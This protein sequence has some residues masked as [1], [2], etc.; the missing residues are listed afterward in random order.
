MPNSLFTLPDD[1]SNLTAKQL[2]ELV[3]RQQAIVEAKDRAYQEKDRAYQEKERAYQEIERAYQE[4]ARAYQQKD[5]AYRHVSA[6]YEQ[7]KME[8]AILRRINFI[9]RSEQLPDL[10]SK[11]FKEDAETDLADLETTLDNLGGQLAQIID[12]E[13]T[14]RIP[15]R[16]RLPSDLPSVDIRHE[17]ETTTCSCGAEMRQMGDDVSQKLDYV[18]GT[19][20]VEN[21]IRPKYVCDCC[22]TLTQAP[23]PA[24][25]IDKGLA[26]TGLLASVLIMKYA[27]HLPLYRQEAIFER[28]GLR[29]ARSTLADWVG[30]CGAQ[31]QPLVDALRDEV[32]A[33][34][35]LHADETPVTFMHHKKDKPQRGYFWTYAPGA[36]ETMKAV[37][38]DF[39]PGRSG[40]H[41]REFLGDWRGSLMCDDYAGYKALFASGQVIEGGCWAHARRK[42]HDIYQA[43]GSDVAEQAL[44][45]IQR[46][47]QY[48][49][50][51]KNLSP[52]A[53]LAHRKRHMGPA[54][55]EFETWLRSQFEL[56]PPNSAIAKA[57]RYSLS[58]W[59]AL[60]RL[61]D[62][63]QLP[64]DNNAVEN[65][66]RP[67]AIGRKNWLFVGSEKAGRRAAAVMSL[68]QSAKLNGHDP[69]AYLKDVL[70][71][72]PTHK[73]KDIA[74][75]LP[76]HWQP[77]AKL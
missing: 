31:L 36:Y 25:I 10:Q 44:W 9:K 30:S 29:I 18:P 49:A 46:L 1:L 62:D 57:I 38:Y 17:L 19:F 40:A 39:K 11:L 65:L 72:L 76:H 28:S 55:D 68:I 77:N 16:M 63:S 50:E 60:T 61:L 12:K 59:V 15:A 42:F 75:L 43:N 8:L 2:R 41:A 67:L 37:I 34:S 5:V 20:S 51:A 32:L 7:V 74:E 27:D 69:H 26:T 45:Q 23:V 14:P 22:K 47:Y 52:P 58:N 56:V 3:L 24:H 48:E 54:L 4:K 6:A 70:T 73:A 35:V 53:R 21:H 33:H 66:I 13:H 64:M 71:R